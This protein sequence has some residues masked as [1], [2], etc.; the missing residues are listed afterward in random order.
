[1]AEKTLDESSLLVRNP[2]VVLQVPAA[3]KKKK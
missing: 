1:M 3:K 2:D